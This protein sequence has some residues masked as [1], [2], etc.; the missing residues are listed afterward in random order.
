M[1]SNILIPAIGCVLLGTQGCANMSYISSGALTDDLYYSGSS[2]LRTAQAQPAEQVQQSDVESYHNRASQYGGFYNQQQRDER[3]F[4]DIQQYYSQQGQQ[5]TSANYAESYAD[6]LALAQQPTDDGY[7]VDGF[8]GSSYDQ[9]YAERMIRFHGPFTSVT[10][11]SP[12]FTSA[13]YSGDWNIY[14]DNG[15]AYFVP[16]WTNPYYN[17]F[18]YGLG[19][20]W[21]R[22]HSRWSF[23]WHYGYNYGWDLAWGYDPWYYGWSYPYYHNHYYG[24]YHPHHWGNHNGWYG[25]G[26][27]SVKP[28]S[29]PAHVYG[30]RGTV[31]TGSRNN[32]AG[33]SD[34]SGRTTVRRTP[35]SYSSGAQSGTVQRPSGA[36]RSY[37]RPTTAVRGGSNGVA[38]RGNASNGT[39]VRSSG[40][41][42]TRV[43]TRPANS[44]TSQRQ[45]SGTT[46]SSYTPN[47]SRSVRSSS[48]AVRSQSSRS[49]NY[50]PSR[51]SSS[52]RS[53]SRSSSSVG[54]SSS[55]MRSSG[56]S[57][58]SSGSSTA[59]RRR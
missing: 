46:R 29:R 39:A 36:V 59:T 20:D 8:W 27:T 26:G 50:T 12:L 28:S 41:Q 9:S 16:T 31:A 18:Y 6:T 58:R 42:D 24:H 10:Y 43:S 56:G 30:P 4:S 34:N 49:S 7:W 35:N 48:S 44:S 14:M 57:V 32:I 11:Y 53:T 25:N 38:V 54:T 52:V 2:Q 47:G 1:K 13:R 23:G 21:R 17:D 37:T 22:A 51:S 45:Q 33:T 3:D 40:N 55:G 5:Q 19:F 15:Y